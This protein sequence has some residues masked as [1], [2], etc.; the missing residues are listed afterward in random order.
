M[1]VAGIEAVSLLPRGLAEEALPLP[2]HNGV[3]Q[4]LK[5]KAEGGMLASLDLRAELISHL[6]EPLLT[7]SG[8]LFCLFIHFNPLL[9]IAAFSI[10]SKLSTLSTPLPLSTIFPIPP[11]LAYQRKDGIK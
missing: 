5:E 9:N 8:V 10:I 4:L 6:L 7:S 3:D 1:K 11:S 2:D